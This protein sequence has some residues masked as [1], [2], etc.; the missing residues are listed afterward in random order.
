MTTTPRD[1]SSPHGAH[2]DTRADVLHYLDR[3]AR[4]TRRNGRP[5]HK[6]HRTCQA[7][8]AAV[9]LTPAQVRALLLSLAL[10]ARVIEYQ[11]RKPGHPFTYSLPAPQGAASG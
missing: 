1:T 10:E 8:A 7:V 11:P 9:D 2:R 3:M 4:A 5:S 6:A